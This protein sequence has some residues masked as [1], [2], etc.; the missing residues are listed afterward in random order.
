MSKIEKNQR[1]GTTEISDPCFHLEIFD[2]LYDANIIITKRLTDKLIDKII[3]NKEKIILH[4]TVTGMGGSKIEPLVP[5][6]EWSYNQIKKLIDKGF[7][8]KQ[9]VLRVDPIIPTQKGINTAIE[10]IKLFCIENELGINRVRVSFLDMY[11]HVKKRFIENSIQLPYDTFHAEEVN[12]ENAIEILLS[13]T[14]DYDI[15]LEFCGEPPTDRFTNMNSTPCVSQKDINILGLTDKI[16]LV[17]NKNARRN[18]GCPE[19]K[20]ELIKDKPKQC[21]NKCLY[22]F[23]QN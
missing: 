2:N 18:C 17:G 10:V 1:I 14:K 11:E 13:L 21:N 12:R 3:E 5:K 23:W 16:N 22:C 20:Y 4:C 9:I 15:E 7:P 6:K 19:N 8:A